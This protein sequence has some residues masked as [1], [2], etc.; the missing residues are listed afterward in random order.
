M[1]AVACD[2]DIYTG[3][4]FEF[5]LSTSIC[6]ILLFVLI[7]NTIYNEYWTT[8]C[9]HIAIKS[10]LL[11]II[12]QIVAI[13]YI[14]NELFRF[15]IDPQT[16]ILRDRLNIG[17][18]ISTYS[19][20]VILGVY[21]AIYLYQILL[22]L[23]KSFDGSF[24]ALKK[25]T[26]KTISW[27]IIF[28]NSSQPILYCILEG[29]SCRY[30][31]NPPDIST[32]DKFNFCG[33]PSSTRTAPVIIFSVLFNVSINIFLCAIFVN[34]LNKLLS[35]EYKYNNCISFKFKSLIMKNTILTLTA[36]TSTFL[37]YFLWFTNIVGIGG[38][39]IY[40]D[41][42]LNTLVIGLM[43]KYNDHHY[44]RLCKCCIYLCFMHC[45]RSETRLAKEQIMQ[46]IKFNEEIDLSIRSSQNN[47]ATTVQM[48]Q[49]QICTNSPD[50]NKN[51][52]SMPIPMEKV[53]S[54]TLSDNNEQNSN[55]LMKYQE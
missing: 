11:Y 16:H 27:L 19:T 55:V 41:M 8:N 22:R 34:K 43:F 46:Y 35:V 23:E 21:Y 36:A 28:F 40:F 9:Q 50:A 44:R 24:L 3:F 15:T 13:Y 38:A 45:D 37:S 30:Y 42:F 53:T 51:Q 10:R 54:A 52:I 5:A 14:G 31:W 32:N 1:S 6:I 17:C 4:F 7:G 47:N 20:K 2:V 29:T 49:Q 25:S 26:F 48:A 33:L 18:N 12:L 39:F